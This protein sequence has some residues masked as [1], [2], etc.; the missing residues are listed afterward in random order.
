[1]RYLVSGLPVLGFVIQASGQERGPP[2]AKKE[3]EKRGVDFDRS[4]FINAAIEGEAELVRLFLQA[5]LDPDTEFQTKGIRVLV[6]EFTLSG[7]HLDVL[8]VV[9]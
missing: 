9:V 5:G 7:G 8:E 6:S 2:E 1:M 4:S 3:I